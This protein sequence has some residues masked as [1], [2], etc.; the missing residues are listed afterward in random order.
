[1]MLFP[2]NA[3]TGFDIHVVEAGTVIDGPD[4]EKITVTDEQV[5]LNGRECFVTQRIYDALKKA[6]KP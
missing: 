6:S 3:F 2:P 1:M 5:A 4:S